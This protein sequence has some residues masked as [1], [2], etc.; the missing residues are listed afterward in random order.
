M[1]DRVERLL[2]ELSLSTTYENVPTSDIEAVQRGLNYIMHLATDEKQFKEFGKDIFQTFYDVSTIAEEPVRRFALLR[3]EV[4]AQVWL[5]HY[6][7]LRPAPEP[8][9]NQVENDA[10]KKKKKEEVNE[11]PSSDDI[12]DF[13]MVC[14]IDNIVNWS[15]LLQI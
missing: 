14:I 5:K 4:L 2:Q 10:K 1:E 6:P 11:D 9:S 3:T 12:L 15:V 13:I 7:T 8:S